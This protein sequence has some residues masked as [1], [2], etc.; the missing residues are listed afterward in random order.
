MSILKGRVEQYHDDQIIVALSDLT[1]VKSVLAKFG[2]QSGEENPAPRLGLALLPLPAVAAD[3]R[4]LRQDPGGAELIRAATA[5]WRAGLAAGPRIA[6]IPDLDLLMLALRAYFQQHFSGWVPPMGKNRVVH[7]G[8]EGFPHIRFG[9]LG[10]PTPAGGPDLPWPARRPEPGRDV[11]V[12][13]LDTQLSEN[14]WLAGG[15][16]ASAEGLIQ[17]ASSSGLLPATAGHATFVAGLILRRAPGAELD[18][19]PVLDAAALGDVWDA[20]RLIADLAGS[21]IDVLNLSF[22]CFTD[23]G[24]PPLA[25]ARA[26]GLVSP[27][28]VVVA[29]A[30]NY[31]HADLTEGLTRTTPVWPAALDAVVAVGASDGNG[32]PASFSPDL[33]WTHFLAPGVDVESTYLSGRVSTESPDAQGRHATTGGQAFDGWA[34][35]SGTSFAAAAVSG[36]IAARTVPGRRS[37]REALDDLRRPHRDGPDSDITSL[38]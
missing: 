4:K 9:G 8:L 22:G 3:I 24:Q 28:I 12:G 6:E 10:N 13:L 25:L 38:S 32:K 31:D 34:R 16:I 20:A 14:P 2:L 26:I 23:D 1:E 30:G 11:R 29:A 7:H 36:A 37:A 21:G 18:I 17:P 35:W 5:A 27:E 15:Y 19:R 33:P